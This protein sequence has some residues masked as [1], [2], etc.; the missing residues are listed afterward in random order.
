MNALK[1]DM[2]IDG[3]TAG[4]I[5]GAGDKVAETMTQM[6]YKVTMLN[7]E[8]ITSDYLKQFDV[9]V[10]GVRAYNIHK[11]LTDKYDVLMKYVNDGGVLLNQYNTNNSIGPLVAKMSP[12]PFTI[13]RNRVTERS[14]YEG[15]NVDSHYQQFFSM[16]DSGAE[17]T[18]GSLLVTDY[19]KG[20]Y[21][22]S[23]LVFFREL[24]AAV[25]GAYRLF[26]NLLAKPK[27]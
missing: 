21:I 3:K 20:K 4:Y 14:T 13:S 9:I 16:K 17:A 11:W 7:E 25:P 26:A 22:Y 5:A 27:K 12:Y 18:T 1:L 15:F 24:P 8:N 6:G 2:K 10:T 19:G 23:S